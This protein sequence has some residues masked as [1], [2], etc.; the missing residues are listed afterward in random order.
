MMAFFIMKNYILQIIFLVS[1]VFSYNTYNDDDWFFIINPKNIKSITQD[2][3][4]MHFLAENGI[5]SYDLITQDFFYNTNLSN[6]SI[7][8]KKEFIHYEKSNDYFFVLTKKYIYHKSS[9][10]SYWNQNRLSNFNISSF[11]SIQNIGFNNQYIFFKSKNKYIVV[12]IFSM[13]SNTYKNL[14]K[15]SDINWINIENEFID[16]T[17]FYTFNDDVIYEDY[18]LDESGVQNFVTSTAYDKYDNLWIGMSTG[19]IYKVEDSSFEIVRID[20]GPRLDYISNIYKDKQSNWYFADNY[21]RRTGMIDSKYDGYLV[22]IWNE[23]NNQWK[24]IAKNESIFA[25]DITI[26]NIE[27]FDRFIIFATFKGL[28]IY[29]TSNDSWSQHYTFLN[30]ANRV[31]W[32]I[33]FFDEKVYFSTSDGIV[34][35]T[36][37][38]LD[39]ELEF[40]FNKSILT[41]YEIYDIKFFENELYIASS[42]GLYNYNISKDEIAIIDDRK[43]YNIEI[44]DSYILSSNKN[45]WYIDDEGR[46]LLSNRIENFSVNDSQTIVCGTDHYEIKVIDLNSQEEWILTLDYFNRDSF[47]YTIGCDDQWLWFVS[48][49]GTNFFKWS[50]YEK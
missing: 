10:A 41:N 6:K 33:E 48:D 28:V 35:C 1:C 43:Y 34:E 20:T 19:A 37:L 9:V 30:A 12:D 45:L 26:N 7:D 38:I 42:Q 8:D 15:F 14:E 2:S 31:V 25:S 36:W 49:Q 29:D 17:D 3:F 32:D 50:N 22:S 13:I 39:D 21:F 40:Y 46:K 18:I 5:F 24:H 16:L 27:K 11:S 47:I 23:D 4:N 44:F